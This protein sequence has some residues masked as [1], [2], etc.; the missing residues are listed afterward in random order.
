MKIFTCTKC[1][2]EINVRVLEK[3]KLNY[4]IKDGNLFCS[5]HCS[6]VYNKYLPNNVNELS[7]KSIKK[8]KK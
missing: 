8:Y 5:E 2:I 3:E 7:R 1:K 6:K 4:I